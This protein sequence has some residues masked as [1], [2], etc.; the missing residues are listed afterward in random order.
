MSN[1]RGWLGFGLI[2]H[3]RLNKGK[4][5]FWAREASYKKVT[6]KSMTKNGGLVRFVMQI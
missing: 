4:G 6:R 2:Y 1:P 5:G 3:L